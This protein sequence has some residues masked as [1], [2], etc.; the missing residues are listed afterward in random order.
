[1]ADEDRHSEAA[2]QHHHEHHHRHHHHHHYGARIQA[3]LSPWFHGMTVVPLM[4][5]LIAVGVMPIVYD[6]GTAYWLPVE[7]A[8][9]TA[10]IAVWMIAGWWCGREA[11]HPH[12]HPLFWLFGLLVLFGLF[13]QRIPND[14]L[15]KLFSSKASEVWRSFN[16]LGLGQA[17]ATLSLSPDATYG[18]VGL[19]FIAMVLFF[20]VTSICRTKLTL[21]L[22]VL[23]VVLAALG[24]AVISFVDFFSSGKSGADSWG[25]FTGAF[26]NR[27]H[28]GFMMMMGILSTMGLMAGVAV[29]DDRKK[30]A[31]GEPLGPNILIPVATVGFIL[32]AAL[33]LSLSRGAFLGTVVG[34]LFFG[35]IWLVQTRKER[36]RNKQMIMVLFAM[37]L[38]TLVL[39]MP[40]ALNALSERYE[41]LLEGDLSLNDRWLVWKGT[42][43]VIR[44]YWLT[45]CGLGAFGDVI[46][47]YDC[48]IYT[49]QLVG[50]AHNDY[51]EFMAE[52]GVPVALLVFGA[53]L[54]FWVFSLRRCLHAHNGVYRWLGIGALSAMLGCAIHEAADYN[55]LAYSNTMLYATLL[56]VIAVCA[57]HNR[58]P[59]SWSFLTSAEREQSRMERWQW[60]LVL[61]PTSLVLLAC[62]I[63]WSSKR[64]FAGLAANSLFEEYASGNSIKAGRFEYSRRVRYVRD[65]MGMKGQTYRIARYSAVTY[66][67]YARVDSVKE[68]VRK[69]YIE[70]ACSD[71]STA[72]RLAPLDGTSALIAARVF[73]LANLM[74][75]R[76]DSHDMVLGLYA[77]AHRCHPY[78][79]KTVREAALAAYDAYLEETDEEKAAK[80]RDNALRGMTTILAHSSKNQSQIYDALSTMLG[81]V[82]SLADYAPDTMRS[83][84]PLL[85]Y[86][87]S[88]RHYKD[89][90]SLCDSLLAKA[91][92]PYKEYVKLEDIP[93]TPEEMMDCTLDLLGKRCVLCE[94]LGLDGELMG[95]WDAMEQQLFICDTAFITSRDDDDEARKRKASEKP[96]KEERSIHVMTPEGIVWQAQ[97]ALD[98][99]DVDE[100]INKL[101]Q[102][103]YFVDRKVDKAVLYKGLELLSGWRSS[104]RPKSFYRARF[105]QAALR[106]MLAEQ[107]E[108]V[109][110]MEFV[111]DLEKLEEEQSAA[112]ENYWIQMHLVPYYLGRS[113]ELEGEPDLAMEA[114]R[115]CLDV[116]PD[117]LWAM[118]CL[119]RLSAGRAESL[120]TS[121]EQALMKIVN[122]RPRPIAYMA[123]AIQWLGVSV[124]PDVLSKMHENPMVE[125]LFLCIGDVTK[126]YSW[127]MQFTDAR[128][129]TFGDKVSFKEAAELTWKAGQLISVRQQIKPFVAVMSNKNSVMSNGVVRVGAAANT[130]PL[131]SVKAFTID[132][133]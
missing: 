114:Y 101:M 36:G 105:L 91:R 3:L 60:R 65:S 93:L 96:D 63:P 41:K 76:K 92:L 89:A 38:L 20:L 72:V 13:F 39:S 95:A 127:K 70:R 59:E 47:S 88:S 79:P 116:C 17:K 8:F 87:I 113:Q 125:Y 122:A 110:F 25:V 26:I 32:V 2:E 21:K 108:K 103:S 23:A 118:R 4:L 66:A 100:V 123:Q 46:E 75:I 121:H 14:M 49:G 30:R 120:L 55:L 106:I 22:V 133:Q 99:H 24:N 74:K 15:V 130:I 94:L 40:Y 111:I 86:L 107:G 35:G 12:F 56:A 71:I 126:R 77:W 42:C 27:N 131:Q 128:G 119:E 90:L 129:N 48:H 124:T 78:L 53:L 6:G 28:F 109:D 81:S 104:V 16:A 54:W 1:M 58:R 52:V 62:A 31:F 82:D 9:L 43:R 7:L 132:L 51:L 37:T 73:K 102:L 68:N 29:D 11:N 57:S 18:R 50:H 115:R 33:I 61:L 5:V 84:V 112:P 97:K 80:Y 44:D 19:L 67:D 45:G 10:G 98:S 85:D 117:N 34:M 69:K 64:I 83:R